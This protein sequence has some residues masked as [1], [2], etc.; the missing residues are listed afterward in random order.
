VAPEI[1][2]MWIRIT[3]SVTFGGAATLPGENLIIEMLQR[4][5]MTDQRGEVVSMTGASLRQWAQ[6]MLGAG[7]SDPADLV[8]GGAG[9]VAFDMRFPIPFESRRADIPWDFRKP[10]SDL[11]GPGSQIVLQ[12]SSGTFTPSASTAVLAAGASVELYAELYDAGTKRATS[13]LQ[14][15]DYV[16]PSDDFRYEV[17][18][19]L[20][21]AWYSVS[22]ADI[23]AGTTTS[24]ARAY[25]SDGLAYLNYAATILNSVYQSQ[26][27]SVSAADDISAGFAQNLYASCNDQAIVELPDL[28][29]L[30][31]RMSVA[32]DSGSLVCIGALTPRSPGQVAQALGVSTAALPAVAAAS[33]TETT[34]ET[35]AR[36]ALPAKLTAFLPLRSPKAGG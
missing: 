26:L 11:A 35:K 22:S 2:T 32:H 10:V 21:D 14:L 5:L 12:L 17:N 27:F 1:R 16:V 23:V 4:V 6:R 29:E 24:A 19:L 20:L 13:R 31:V 9:N 36:A 30:Q 18:G 3:G 28:A 8:A 7:Y 15:R 33:M 34:T 25:I